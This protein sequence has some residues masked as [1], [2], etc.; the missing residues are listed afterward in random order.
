MQA[1]TGRFID[2]DHQCGGERGGESGSIL[3]GYEIGSCLLG[4]GR[5]SPRDRRPASSQD[6]FQQYLAALR[7]TVLDGSIDPRFDNAVRIPPPRPAAVLAAAALRIG[8]LKKMF[9]ALGDD[10]K[11]APIRTRIAYFH[12]VGYGTLEIH[13]NPDERL[14]NP[15][16]C[17][18]ALTGRRDLTVCDTAN[19]CASSSSP[20]FP[21]N[22]PSM[23]RT[24]L[25]IRHHDMVDDDRVQTFSE[26]NSPTPVGYRPY[27][28]ARCQ[29]CRAMW[30][31]MCCCLASAL[32]RKSGR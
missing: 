26:T 22:G 7:L 30:R 2:Q 25:L 14:L 6:G 31:R 1:K 21:L 24:L 32:A 12:R 5:P 8:A 16:Y 23:S 18:E 28:V 27:R 17:A 29:N 20:A 13:D 11:R 3:A 19:R 10:A 9:L 15:R 4:C